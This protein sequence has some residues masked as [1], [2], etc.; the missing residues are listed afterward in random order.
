MSRAPRGAGPVKAWIEPD[1]WA[2]W[3]A[4]PLQTAASLGVA[5]ASVALA[6]VLHPIFWGLSFLSLFRHAAAQASLRELWR[7]GM[8]HPSRVV[9]RDCLAT[10]VRLE[11]DTGVQDAIMISRLP[12]RWRTKAPPWGG[13]RAAVVIAGQPPRLRPLS[14][15][16]AV[17]DIDRARRATERIPEVQWRALELG[18]AQLSDM[19][20]G[21]HPVQLGAEPWY[22][23]LS[24]VE[25][26]G[27]LPEHLS[28]TEVEVWCAGLPCIEQPE[29]V[30]A[31]A[32]RI[33]AHRKRALR[34]FVMY[35]LLGVGL[36]VAFFAALALAEFSAQRASPVL[37]IVGLATFVGAPFFLVMAAS[38]FGRARAYKRDLAG[39]KLLRFAGVLSSFDSLALDPDLALLTRRGML[40]PEP[41][42]EQD[43][44]VL[45]VSSE[46]L[47]AN[48]RWAPRGV[49]LHIERVAP[50]PA[51][52]LKLP[53]P[54]D[55]RAQ[56]LSAV[57][58]ARRR[59][60]R[61]EVAELGRHA[62]VLRRPGRLFW[63][64]AGFAALAVVSW[65][66]QG[67]VWPPRPVTIPVAL[68]AWGLAIVNVLKRARLAD[69]LGRDAELGWVLTVDHEGHE[70]EVEL[71]AHGVE[72]LLHSR[73]DWTINRRPATWRRFGVKSD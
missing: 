31:E 65:H 62:E 70:G 24:Q 5:V 25:Q 30:P 45:P 28:E 41:G 39:G 48:R 35:A 10:L 49:R 43:M 17:G 33:V 51:D 34:L 21:L 71:P 12:R 7:E 40:A 63:M 64:L 69:M 73:L 67:W 47:Y 53:L 66:T 22:G 56:A 72:T 38:L 1:R 46:L 6:Y 2:F 50:P 19:K 55:V 26:A 32:A 54:E 8:L 27:S 16:F 37:S 15:D 52:P 3:R 57:S 59:F 9:A 60:T 42:I 20:E 29:L 61:L 11:G 68:A 14:A 36:P 18:L 23:T 58:V 4:F 44:V 13:D